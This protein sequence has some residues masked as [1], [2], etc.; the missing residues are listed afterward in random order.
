MNDSG[1]RKHEAT[2]GALAA[3]ILAAMLTGCRDVSSTGD[4][5][6]RQPSG[7]VEVEQRIE[8]RPGS[9]QVYER[10]E[11]MTDC[12]S[13]QSEFDQAAANTD[14]Y[15]PGNPKRAVTTSYMAAAVA[16]MGELDCYG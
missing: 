11:A 16:R 1:R 2:V 9:A 10:I 4:V 12:A 8:E 14:R 13:L 6:E 7:S 5:D 3:A 15:E